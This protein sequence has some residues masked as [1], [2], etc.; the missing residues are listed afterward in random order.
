M[1]KVIT[2]TDDAQDRPCIYISPNLREL[3]N[4]LDLIGYFELSSLV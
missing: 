3:S 4:A 2:W 1:M